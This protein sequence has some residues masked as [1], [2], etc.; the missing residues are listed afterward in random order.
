ML[1]L[2]FCL[3]V[4]CVCTQHVCVFRPFVLHK[5]VISHSQ[6][7]VSKTL[8]SCKWTEWA[9]CK[10]Q[11][12]GM[13][14][15][16]SKWRCNPVWHVSIN[17]RFSLWMKER[18]VPSQQDHRKSLRSVDGRTSCRD[19]RRWVQ[20]TLCS[21]GITRCPPLTSHVHNQNQGCVKDYWQT[22]WPEI[23]VWWGQHFNVVFNGVNGLERKPLLL[24]SLRILKRVTA[25]NNGFC[26]FLPEG[27]RF[28]SIYVITCIL[29]RHSTHSVHLV[30]WMT[31]LKPGNWF[32]FKIC[33]KKKEPE[34]DCSSFLGWFY[35]VSLL[36]VDGINLQATYQKY[37]FK[38][39]SVLLNWICRLIGVWKGFSPLTLQLC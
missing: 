38:H 39:E 24:F 34:S 32:D 19:R 30:L 5:S 8:T 33:K 21:S 17:G 16:G 1:H 2:K 20:D 14:G 27:Q 25:E 18:S 26:I 37:S 7:D 13:R 9:V 36:S 31:L 28:D 6:R 3:W 4:G 12:L 22:R 29:A 10:K 15:V 35:K 11:R 23:K